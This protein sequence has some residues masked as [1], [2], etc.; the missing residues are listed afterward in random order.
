MRRWVGGGRRNLAHMKR[1]GRPTLPEAPG[2]SYT[3]PALGKRRGANNHIAKL[4]ISERLAVAQLARLKPAELAN[5]LV[6]LGIL[7]DQGGKCSE[8]KEGTVK[9]VE[10]PGR[11]SE[12]TIGTCEITPPGQP[13]WRCDHWDCQKRY[14]NL[15]P[16]GPLRD[17]FGNGTVAPWRTL[18]AIAHYASAHATGYAS[19]YELAVHVGIYRNTAKHIAEVIRSIQ[20]KEA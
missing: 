8:C 15:D 13:M 1:H 18:M 12:S 20:A 4:P 17:L 16:T 19:S 9:L 11:G 2:P 14:I 5:V 10:R 3:D 6:E 7:P